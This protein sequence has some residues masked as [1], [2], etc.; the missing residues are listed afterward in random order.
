M[1]VFEELGGRVGGVNKGAVELKKSTHG[2]NNLLVSSVF[3]LM[4]IY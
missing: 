2:E 4:M 1:R 3:L